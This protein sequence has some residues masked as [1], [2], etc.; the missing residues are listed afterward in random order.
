ME[1]A[2]TCSLEQ[3][4]AHL[5]TILHQ[6]TDLGI[7]VGEERLQGYLDA[8]AGTT[9]LPTPCRD[10]VIPE[11]AVEECDKGHLF[12]HMFSNIY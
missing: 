8:K 12:I 10:R 11:S 6:V 1:R 5:S 9:D 3:V 2:S 4:L 7:R